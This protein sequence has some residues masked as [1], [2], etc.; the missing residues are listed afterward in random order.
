MPAHIQ[1]VDFTSDHLEAAVS[2]SVSVGWPHQRK[3]WAML[4]DLSH[5]VVACTEDRIVGTAFRT[6]FGADQSC[7]N[8]VIVDQNLRGT[9]VGYALTSAALHP[10]DN[11][12][13]R[14]VATRL[15]KPLYQKLGFT[16][17]GHV[18]QMMG[19]VG[20]VPLAQS[21][22]DATHGDLRLVRALDTQAF[23]G[24]RTGLIN[25]L[26]EHSQI[27]V[28]RTDEH[29]SGYAA[30][31]R[32]G[33]GYVIGPVVANT[34]EAAQ[35]LI[36]YLLHR[37]PRHIVRIDIQEES[38]LAPWLENLGLMTVDRPTVMTRGLVHLNPT[39]CALFS[40]AL[41]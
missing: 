36:L 3:D 28:T 6:D 33:P 8:M 16:V 10:D 14:L 1:I 39:Y 40:Q 12:A 2:L 31:R 17:A 13:H 32:F 22:S 38:G 37:V 25:W 19:T 5:G 30:L 20:S 21:I 7:I 35:N 4:L 27:A 41:S 18:L 24:D 34:L 15:G 23:G 29:I 26:F 9:G 11:R